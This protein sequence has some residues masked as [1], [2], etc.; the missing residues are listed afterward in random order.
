MTYC[1]K[2]A[3]SNQYPNG[4]ED[5]DMLSNRKIS[6]GSM[7][8]KSYYAL[9]I[10]VFSFFSALR[11]RVGIDC[12][13]YKDI[14]YEIM[15]YDGENFIASDIE[16]GFTLLAQAVGF[17][18]DTHYLFMFVLAFLQISLLYY[19]FRKHTNIIYYLGLAIFLTGFYWSLMNGIRQN[20]VAC[21]KVL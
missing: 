18:T 17:F 14:F 2:I 13:T 20:I 16:E 15:L 12:E 5:I 3:Y 10:L 8:T 1:G 6:F 21:I 4:Y 11:Y 9:P 7:F 19:A